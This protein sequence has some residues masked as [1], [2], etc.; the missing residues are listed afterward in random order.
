LFINVLGIF[1]F[2]QGNYLGEPFS[3]FQLHIYG[4]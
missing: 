4:V 2:T 3:C 1:Y